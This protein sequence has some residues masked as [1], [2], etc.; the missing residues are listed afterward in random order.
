MLHD[1]FAAVMGAQCHDDLLAEIV[2]L[3]RQL[4]FETVT[5][6]AVV[7]RPAADPQF[8][9]VDNGPAGFAVYA[10]NRDRNRRD[11][12]MQHCKSS[13]VPIV[14]D[15]ATY[16]DA[17]QAELWEE[18]ARFG[19][20]TGICLAVHLPAGR[21]FC[22]GVDRDQALPRCE[23]EVARMAGDLHLFAA[24]VQD[25]AFRVLVP[26]VDTPSPPPLLTP[27]ELE[28]LRWTTEGKTA[29]EVGRLLGISEQTAVRHLNNAS[30]KLDSVNKHHAVV[31]A[32][33][34][35]LIR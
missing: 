11:P 10:E 16:V 19:Y 15:Q 20:R 18:Q 8:H 2:R 25:A 14:W 26:V 22:I 7:D 13:S 9:C 27:R 12:V 30:K 32:M 31:K 21:H 29:W 34:L 6:I 23:N 3:T 24:H 4:E 17:G 33:R 1:R 28:C 5:A 35:G